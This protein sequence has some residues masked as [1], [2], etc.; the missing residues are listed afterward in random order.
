M[1][2]KRLNSSPNKIKS[3][4]AAVQK[5]NAIAAAIATEV[6]IRKV[7]KKLTIKEQAMRGIQDFKRRLYNQDILHLNETATSAN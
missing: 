3:Y 5:R 4:N 7:N 2:L 6:P 1:N